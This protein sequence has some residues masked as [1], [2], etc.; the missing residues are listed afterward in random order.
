MSFPNAELPISDS[1]GLMVFKELLNFIDSFTVIMFSVEIVLK[2]IDN[3][4]TFWRNPW[5]VFDLFVTVLVRAVFFLLPPSLYT[6]FCPLSL[7]LLFRCPLITPSMSFHPS[8]VLLCLPSTA[9]LYIYIY[10]FLCRLIPPSHSFYVCVA[11]WIVPVMSM[12][13]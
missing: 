6:S 2:W 1:H 4:K 9:S 12:R 3:F 13:V 11:L 5:N 7:L 10:I 8:S